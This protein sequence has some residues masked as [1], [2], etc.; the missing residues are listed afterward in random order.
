ML[1]VAPARAVPALA[2]LVVRAAV[3]LVDPVVPVVRPVLVDPVVRAPQPVPGALPV[4]ICRV[5]Q[6]A[7]TTR[8]S[9]CRVLAFVLADPVDLGA[10][11]VPVVAAPVGVVPVAAV[12]AVARPVRSASRRASVVVLLRSSL[13]PR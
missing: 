3:V 5:A 9:R 4:R 6:A 13:R 10:P 8:A 11:A 12:Q 7:V 2:G 1:L